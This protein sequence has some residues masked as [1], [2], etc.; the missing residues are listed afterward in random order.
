MKFIKSESIVEITNDEIEEIIQLFKKHGKKISAFNLAGFFAGTRKFQKS[1]FLTH[2]LYG[3]Y[4]STYSKGQ[5][6]DFFS[7]YSAVNQVETIGKRYYESLQKDDF[8]QKEKFNRLS[9]RAI[10]QLKE[11]VNELGII[12]TENLSENVILARKSFPRAY[13]HWGEKELSLLKTAINYTNDLD[14]LSQCFQR[15]KGSIE[16][17]GLKLLASAPAETSS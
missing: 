7:Q 10:V 13:E 9:E 12:K 4:A 8:F 11:K 15:G 5:L 2:V 17:M 3:K 16:S 1:D 14:L 6:I